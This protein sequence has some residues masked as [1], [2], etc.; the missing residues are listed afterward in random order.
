MRKFLGSKIAILVS[1]GLAILVIIFLIASL[2]SL[3]FKPAKSF[4]YIQENAPNSPGGL[5][6]WNGFVYVIVIFFALLII[7][8]IL[9]PPDQRKKFLIRLAWLVLTGVI[10][11]LIIS[12]IN[13]ATSFQPTQEN[14]GEGAVTVVPVPTGTPV[15]A[16]TPSIFVPPQVSSWTSYFVA[17]GILLIVVVLWGWILWRRRKKGAPYDALAEIARSTLDDIE[18]GRDW[19]DAILNSY[20]RMTRVVAD[21]RGIRRGLS[22]TPAEFADYLVSAHL[23]GEAVYPLTAL[24]ERVRYGDKHSTRKEIQEAVD[25]LNAI[26]DYCQEPK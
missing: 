12:R 22:M 23:P 24:F 25:S 21:W 5:P 11:A 18:A 20:F 13:L 17:L 10:I 14:P 2:G 16:V 9:L 4:A 1:G 26:L 3:E 6:S 7:L 8:I 15:P 19:G